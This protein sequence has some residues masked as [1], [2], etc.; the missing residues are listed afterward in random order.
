M[1]NLILTNDN[2]ELLLPLNK[3]SKPFDKYKFNYVNKSNNKKTEA[4]LIFEGED[5]L[6]FIYGLRKYTFK[7]GEEII[8]QGKRYVSIEPSNFTYQEFTILSDLEI[9]GFIK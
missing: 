1:I 3:F 6:Y 4:I 9:R 2:N 8:Q 5:T 7:L